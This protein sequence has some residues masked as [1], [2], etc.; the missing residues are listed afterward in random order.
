ML[1]CQTKEENSL[2]R[3]QIGTMVPKG[4]SQ[5]LRYSVT[6]AKEAIYDASSCRI[7]KG[8]AIGVFFRIMLHGERLPITSGH[9]ASLILRFYV[10]AKRSMYYSMYILV[11][12]YPTAQTK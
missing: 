12:K 1:T 5:I 8:S 9:Q 7:S 3:Q 11:K 10:P 6:A 4:K 2:A